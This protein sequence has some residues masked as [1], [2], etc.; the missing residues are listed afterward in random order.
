MKKRR[1]FWPWILAALIGLPVLY[2]V[3]FGPACQ[4][5]RDG[6]LSIDVVAQAYCPI[7][8]LANASPDSIRVRIADYSGRPVNG[9]GSALCMLHCLTA[10]LDGIADFPW[11][12]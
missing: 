4:M 9:Y 11:Q 3:S 10:E 8:R 12:P 1:A 5:V 2:I 7:V 6:R